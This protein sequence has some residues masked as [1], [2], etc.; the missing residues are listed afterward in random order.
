MTT[1]ALGASRAVTAEAI[2]AK[3]ASRLSFID[4]IRVFLTI[5][6]ILHHI[7][8][9]YAGSGSWGLYTEGRQDTLSA[10]LGTWFCAVNQAYFMGFFLLIA[11]YFVPGSYD[12]KGARHFLKDRLIRLGIPLLV[13][14]WFISPLSYAV[15]SYVTQG[16]IR[17]WWQYLPG[18]GGAVIGNGPLWFVE[19]LLIFTVVYVAWRRFFRPNAPVPSVKTDSRFP[20][21][22]TLVLFGVLMAA[23]TF[24]VRLVWPMGWEFGLLNLQFPFFVQY[25]ALFVV[26]LI[27][28][29]RNWLASLSDSTGKRWL[30]VAIVLI[31]MFLPMA[32]IGGALETDEPFRGGLYWQS[33][34]YSLW[35]SFVCIGMC[36][37]LTYL[38]RRYWNR[39]GRLAKFLSPNAYTAYIIHAPIITFTA[40]ALRNVD[41][42]P[43]L[44]FGLAVLIALPLCFV[45]SNLIRKLPYTDRVL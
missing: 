43:L 15:V 21:S 37:G 40:L 30:A 17:P 9:I 20:S 44:K 13:Y 4:N 11:A 8:I 41:V 26:G 39:Q 29:R 35:E 14:S 27:A 12:R 31:L 5:L 32:L 38:F 34:A 28:Y 33:L 23:A 22:K 45:L 36:I 1:T 6:V 7:M 42:Y 18:I 25:I 10:V 3:A 2:Q 19:V 16:Q 24:V